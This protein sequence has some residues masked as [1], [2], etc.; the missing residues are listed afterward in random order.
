MDKV[1]EQEK[2]LK[3]PNCEGS[4]TSCFFKLKSEASK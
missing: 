1:N 3:C 2:W 4:E